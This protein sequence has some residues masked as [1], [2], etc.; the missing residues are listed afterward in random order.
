MFQ[1]FYL[2]IDYSPA[3]SPPTQPSSPLPR[4]PKE[5]AA[6]LIAK[7]ESVPSAHLVLIDGHWCMAKFRDVFFF[8]FL[9]RTE[10][11]HECLFK[12]IA[13]D[14]DINQFKES[15]CKKQSKT[16]R[17]AYVCGK[18]RGKFLLNFPIVLLVNI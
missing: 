14:A 15:I 4:P 3:H 11:Y 18:R 1:P 13:T 6:L 7:C 2:E 9:L 17:K 12:L 16:L 8:Y 5:K 10:E